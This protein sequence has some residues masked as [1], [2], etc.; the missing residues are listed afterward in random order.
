MAIGGMGICPDAPLARY[1]S[2]WGQGRS[3]D[4]LTEGG[5]LEIFK[6]NFV[7]KGGKKSKKF[8]APFGGKFGLLRGVIFSEKQ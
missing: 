8:F 7:S 1:W 4:F 3:Q 5:R 2:Q 6:H